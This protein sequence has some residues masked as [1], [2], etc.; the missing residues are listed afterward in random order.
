MGCIQSLAALSCTFPPTA[1]L[2]AYGCS[3]NDS[4]T[5]LKIAISLM[6]SSNLM[7]DLSI[8][9]AL[10]TIALKFLQVRALTRFYFILCILLISVSCVFK[11][12]V[13]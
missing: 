6:T 5:I 3:P 4:C 10:L 8:H 2:E 11:I 9:Q 1:Y 12:K 13:V 7:L